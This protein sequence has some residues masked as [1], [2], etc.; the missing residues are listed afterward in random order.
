MMPSLKIT[1]PALHELIEV[2]NMRKF[3]RL[4]RLH[5][6]TELKRERER[7]DLQGNSVKTTADFEQRY[8]LSL[9]LGA[10]Q[11]QECLWLPWSAVVF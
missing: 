10:T 9:I 4:V 8:A 11:Y 6:L 3:P 1:R 7:E 2:S 5:H